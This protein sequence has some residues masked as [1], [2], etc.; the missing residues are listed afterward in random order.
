MSVKTP[1]RGRWD[2]WRQRFRAWR[3]RRPHR[4]FR[5]TPRRDYWRPLPLPGYWALSVQVGQL[6]WRH[7]WLFCKLLVV[8]VVLALVLST[9][10]SQEA[11]QG[12]QEAVAATSE[13]QG[14]IWSATTLFWQVL[15]GQLAGTLSVVP[16]SAQQVIGALLGLLLW[17][18]TI[19]LLRA[20]TTGARP[21]VR[22][23]LYRAG[24]PLIALTVLTCIVLLQLVP[25]A[26]A[27]LVYS[28]MDASGLLHQT[29]ILMLAAAAMVLIVTLSIYWIVSTLLAMVIVTLPG[30]YPGEALRLAGDLVVGRRVR[31][32][33]RLAWLVMWL[34]ILW[35]VILIPLIMLDGTLKQA[36]P[37]LEWLPL[38]PMAALL[39]AALSV[40]FFAA[41]A[42]T[43][44]RK[45]VEDD[46]ASA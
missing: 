4:S 11:Y 21:L 20:I 30:M 19:W 16:G 43:L 39:L 8:Y 38:V 2:S 31:I 24:T 1:R 34:L 6:L 36:L 33:L 35:A 10:V 32:L 22:D 26:V 45:I 42:Y 41:Y 7:R 15:T 14:G 23:G 46:S 9:A 44:Y 5:R 27:L 17:L 12:I 28:A 25:G 18:T 37:A 13:G 3:A 40:I 29:V